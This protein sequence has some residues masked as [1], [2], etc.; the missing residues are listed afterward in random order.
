MPYA[1]SVLI[2]NVTVLNFVLSKHPPMCLLSNK[3]VVQRPLFVLF[4][5][6][7]PMDGIG[8]EEIGIHHLVQQL[9]SGEIKEVILAT[10]AT[11]EGEVTANYIASLSK[12]RQ[13]KT[14][15]IACGV[16]IGGELEFIDS[17]TLARALAGRGEMHLL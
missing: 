7:S 15:R 10:N 14:S 9:D 12:Q 16:P 3:V 2:L 13:I 4:G 8:P 6:L 17:N 1:I 11:V 5:H